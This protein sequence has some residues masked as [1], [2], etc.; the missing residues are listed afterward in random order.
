MD[1]FGIGPM[2][3]LVILVVALLVFGPKKLPGVAKSLRKGVDSFRKAAS[4]ITE[5]ARKEL[6]L[7]EN[8]EKQLSAQSRQGK[9]AR[10]ARPRGEEAHGGE[11]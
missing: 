3:I 5:E 7:D 4:E 8:E 1:F 9:T 6:E 2:E 11:G 10:S